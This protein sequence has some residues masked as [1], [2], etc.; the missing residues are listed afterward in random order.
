M[1]SSAIPS[2]DTLFTNANLAT[3]AGPGYGKIKDGA[4]AVTSGAIAWT[5]PMDALPPDHSARKTI[6]CRKKWILPGFVDCHTHL[7]WAGSRA[8]EFEMRLSGSSYEDISRAASVADQAVEKDLKT[9]SKFTITPGSET[10]NGEG[11]EE[12]EKK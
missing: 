10:E 2:W 12:T 4:I 8:K 11:T 1:T 6:D 5:G 7:I 3:M 9:K